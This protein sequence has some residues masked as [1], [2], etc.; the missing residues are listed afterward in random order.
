VAV[1]F[2]DSGIVDAPGSIAPQSPERTP[3]E[4]ERNELCQP[5]EDRVPRAGESLLLVLR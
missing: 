5:E 2:L 4:A 3:Q 1:S